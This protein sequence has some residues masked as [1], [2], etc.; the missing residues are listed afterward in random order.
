MAAS[1]A[2]DINRIKELFK[3]QEIQSFQQ[4]KLEAL[5]SRKHG[6]LSGFPGN[7]IDNLIDCYK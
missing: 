3:E 2:L 4:G 6:Y 5:M 7:K 1:S